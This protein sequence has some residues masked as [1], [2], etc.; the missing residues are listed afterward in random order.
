[1]VCIVLPLPPDAE[2]QIDV[3]RLGYAMTSGLTSTYKQWHIA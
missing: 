1:M 3:R 2:E